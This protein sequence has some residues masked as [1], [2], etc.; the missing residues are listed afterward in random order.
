V[1]YANNSVPRFDLG[2]FLICIL[3]L[4][5][6]LLLVFGSSMFSVRRLVEGSRPSLFRRYLRSSDLGRFC[7]LTIHLPRG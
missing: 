2:P 3:L 5:F 7:W 6:V 1:T 4:L